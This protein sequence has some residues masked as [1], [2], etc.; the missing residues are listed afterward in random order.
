[1][2]AL[3]E[4]YPEEVLHPCEILNEKLEEMGMSRKEFSKE[5]EVEVLA[6]APLNENDIIAI[7]EK[8]NTHPA[9]I[10]GRLQHNELIMYSIGRE[11]IQS[12]DLTV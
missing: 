8:F 5:Q 6:A 3:N 9:M 2:A 4:Y 10:I 11:F 12:I 7:A 1:M